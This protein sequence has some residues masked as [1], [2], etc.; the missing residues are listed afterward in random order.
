MPL[1]GHDDYQH[2]H[3][4]VNPNIS[5]PMPLAGHDQTY[6]ISGP[7]D[8]ISTPMPLAGHD[9]H[10]FIER[11]DVADFYSHAPRGA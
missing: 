7:F 10:Y 9:R 11:A 8:S 2:C 5:T 6:S 4:A 3:Y 1:A